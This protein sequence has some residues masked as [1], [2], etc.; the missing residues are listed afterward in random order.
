MHRILVHNDKYDDVFFVIRFVDG[1]KPD[2][3]SAIQLHKPRTVDAA[4]SLALLQ[5]EVLDISHKRLYNRP[6]KEFSKYST[7]PQSNITNT[8]ILGTAP[9]DNKT[10]IPQDSKQKGEDKLTAL[11]AQRRKMGL[12]MKCGDKWSHQHRCPAQIPLHI[13]EEVLN[14]VNSSAEPEV[15]LDSSSSDEE[16]LSLSFAASEGIQGKRS[17][18]LHGLISNQNVLILIDSG[19]SHTFISP[20]AVERL[21]CQLQP[22]SVVHVTAA[23]GAKLPSSQMVPQI[24]WYSQGHTFS[25]TARVLDLSHYDI[26]LG[27]D[28]LE[29]HSPMWVDWKRKKMRFTHKG[30]RITI[31]G[32]KDC[33]A[34]CPQLK[35]KKLKGLVRKGWHSTVSSTDSYSSSSITNRATSCSAT[36][37]QSVCS[38]I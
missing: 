26:I 37:S 34:T 27:M 25:T 13:L 35:I 12:C 8:G 23:N 16:L 32:L 36:I 1:L 11:R 10:S 5:E 28:W 33:T 22:A 19:S 24:S 17:M 18:R 14:A 9:T 4:V 30:K 7:K 20:S 31:S 29:Q 15:E 3:K 21:K 6:A 2:I 38:H